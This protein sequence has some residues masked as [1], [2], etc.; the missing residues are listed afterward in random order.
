MSHP[1]NNLKKKNLSSDGAFH[2]NQR[3]VVNKESY[4]LTPGLL[5]AEFTILHLIG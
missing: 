1:E 5:P 3:L 2:L 4:K